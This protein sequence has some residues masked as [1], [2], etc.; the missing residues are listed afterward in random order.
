M[1]YEEFLKDVRNLSDDFG[2]MEMD[3]FSVMSI[4]ERFKTMEKKKIELA[5]VHRKISQEK[6]NRTRAIQEVRKSKET[7]TYEYNLRIKE[8]KERIDNLNEQNTQL[9]S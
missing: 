6:E 1:V 9:E 8:L 3:D 4:L 7:L 2:P 5:E